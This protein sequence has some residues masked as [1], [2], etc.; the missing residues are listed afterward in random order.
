MGFTVKKDCEKGSQKGGFEK[1]L[2]TFAR[3]VRPLR[4]APY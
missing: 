2:R 4:R 1:V 3:R